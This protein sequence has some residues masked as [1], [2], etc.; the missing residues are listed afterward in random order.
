MSRSSLPSPHCLIDCLDHWTARQPDELLFA[1]HDGR[2]IET[3]RYTYA[4]FARR[5][6][7]LAR[8]LQAQGLRGGQR[9]L[10]VYR[11]GLELVVALFACARLGV[12]G[13]VAPLGGVGGS[14]GVG[15]AEDTA[16]RSQPREGMAAHPRL[17][18]GTAAQVRLRAIARDAAPS[19]VLTHRDAMAASYLDA[20]WFDPSLPLWYT[21]E[22]PQHADP[23]CLAADADTPLLLQYTSGS[24]ADPKGVVVSQANVV[25]N[26]R[27][28]LDH[29]PVGVSWLPQFHDMG[30]I[31]YY[32]FPV[33]MGGR[34]H[35]LRPADFL[36]RPALWLR[37]L[38]AV[39]A[40]Y[41]SAP[42]FGYAY[43]LNRIDE[44]E[45]HGVDLS[46]L[47]VMLNGAEPVQPEVCRRFAQRFARRGLKP[48]VLRAAYGL[49]EATLAVT[50]GASRS[51]RFDADAL[52]RGVAQAV[53]GEDVERSVELACCGPALAGIAL[54]V[55][56]TGQDATQ[57]GPRH[58][59]DRASPLPDGHVGEISVAGPSVTA[60]YWGRE[61]EAPKTLRTGDL[62]FLLDGGLYVW[63]RL[64]DTLIV[65]G[66]NHQPQDLEAAV[67]DALVRT[68]GVAVYQDDARR[69]VL[70]VEA[71]DP[72][73][74]P[75]L[76]R[77]AQRASTA[78]G[79]AIGIALALPPRTIVRT[80]SGKLARA[81]TRR[82]I[83]S[84]QVRPLASWVAAAQEESG[85]GIIERFA[86]AVAAWP[87]TIDGP[88]ADAG[89]DSLALVELQL[90]LQSE[91]QRAGLAALADRLDGPSLQ[92]WRCRDALAL[93]RALQGGDADSIRVCALALC[94]EAEQARSGEQEAMRRDAALPLPASDPS[95][96][97]ASLAAS[98]AA[99]PGSEADA[100]LAA[101]TPGHAP[102]LADHEALV[103][104]GATGFFGPF[105]LAELL[106]LTDAPI[107]VLARGVNDLDARERV[108]RALAR[109]RPEAAGAAEGA[110]PERIVV[111]QSDLA[112]PRLGL[113]DERWRQLTDLRAAIL[114]NGAAVDYVR[115]YAALRP[116][117]VFG[118]RSVVELALAGP[119]K[120]VHH[121][122]S[123][124][125]FGWTRKGVLLE[126]DHNDEMAALDFGY[127]QTKWVAER[128][129]RRA[130]AQGLPVAM[131]R[132]SLISVS[133]SLRG[134]TNDVAARLLAFMI[135]HGVAVDT[136]NQISLL[137]A[138][139]LAHNLVAIALQPLSGAATYHLTA[140]RYHSLTE[141]TRQITHDF[142]FGFEYHDIPGF[143]ARL[144]ALATP[145]D[146]V[147]ALLDFFNRSA[148]H[149]EAMSLKR[150]D[151]E[152]YRRAR[153]ANGIAMPDPSLAEVAGRLVFYLQELGWIGAGVDGER[154]N[155]SACTIQ[156]SAAPATV[157]TK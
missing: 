71:R 118:T 33:V 92:H 145:D 124:F 46:A 22:Q 116:A 45:L 51:R 129:L 144:N 156:A 91:L 28:L 21:E 39:R 157:S 106:D 57:G 153:D 90:E 147:F 89:I 44:S 16:A 47:R 42:N 130:A 100:A 4:Q 29:V 56:G 155:A 27:A 97:S 41:A 136:P 122:S 96:P 141:L 40:T 19:A 12:I 52:A 63:G 102:G 62:G 49:A 69:V 87:E 74:L 65:R 13:V 138:D 60:G 31:G 5:S 114:H 32:L 99:A 54:R 10:L 151:N 38:S 24:T 103:M 50:A 78:S 61:R 143:I 25:A 73:R 15:A 18:E 119:P 140:D 23:F 79:V 2:G 82:A 125:I 131:Y 58:D 105:L 101:S 94:D 127:S 123:T 137:P 104:T 142:G 20:A 86:A 88:I 152:G 110:L 93:I 30:L 126:S 112:A 98:T 36:R 135:R 9:A 76:A 113:S 67:N 37:L 34:T 107:Y 43:C 81:A 132:P 108:R 139:V 95:A 48:G 121:V 6:A 117:N 3:E 111:W 77:I 7:G 120:S 1:F 70:A 149:I 14:G 84:G 148:P 154:Q 150:Y 134:D 17:R 85:T 64:S 66:Q 75:D 83:E 133:R 35:G 55:L 128:L 115:N 109:V 8:F 72:C 53:E 68:H 146:P 59:P 26:A 80:T 11:P